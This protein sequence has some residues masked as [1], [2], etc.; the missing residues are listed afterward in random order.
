MPRRHRGRYWLAF[1]VLDPGTKKC[2]QST[3]RPG[4][5]TPR[6]RD[7][8]PMCRRLD[9][10]RGLSERALKFLPPP[11]DFENRLPYSGRHSISVAVLI[12]HSISLCK[13][14]VKSC[15]V[16]TIISVHLLRIRGM[17]FAALPY[18]QP[19]LFSSADKFF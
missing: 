11:Q 6:K 9:G 10:P 7:L 15:F 19:I 1:P 16:Y 17:C 4:R 5:F 3:P 2:G 18:R 8:V 12:F 14:G 13:F